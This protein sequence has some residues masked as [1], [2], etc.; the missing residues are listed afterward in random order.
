MWRRLKAT[1]WETVGTVVAVPF[2]LLYD[3]TL[4][5]FVGWLQSTFLT[6][7][8]WQWHGIIP[9]HKRFDQWD[10]SNA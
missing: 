7:P 1:D 10:E 2:W 6:G 4:G 5:R 9:I 3:L 8:D